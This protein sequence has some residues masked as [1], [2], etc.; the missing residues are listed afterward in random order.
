MNN[1]KLLAYCQG[2][3]L[4]VKEGDQEQCREELRRI[5]ETLSERGRTITESAGGNRATV[6]SKY[7]AFYK[8]RISSP[9]TP[10]Q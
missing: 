2:E 8:Y 5:L 9:L 6:T 10:N 4:I 1:H 7:G 3:E